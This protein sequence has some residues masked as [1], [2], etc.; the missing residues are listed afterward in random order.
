LNTDYLKNVFRG[1]HVVWAV[2]G[3][4]I[5]IVLITA[6][7]GHPP[8]IV[9]VPVV[10]VIWLAGHA[11]LWISRKLAIRGKYLADSRN[12]AG[13]RRPVMLILLALFSGGLFIFGLFGITWQV[14]FEHDQLHELAVPLAFWIPSSICFFGILLRQNWSRILAGSGFIVVALVLVKEMIESLMRGY[15]NSNAEWAMAIVIAITLVLFGLYILRSSRIKA[16]Y[17]R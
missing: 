5:C 15:R 10:V 13:G 17:S 12:R 2:I 14:F 8:G 11:L 7:G 4:G 3:V 6:K 16:F 1:L 9:L